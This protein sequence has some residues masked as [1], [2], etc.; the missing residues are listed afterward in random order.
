MSSTSANASAYFN[1][2]FFE[3]LREL[4]SNNRREWFEANKRRYEADVKEPMLR[5]I[6]DFGT[7][8]RTISEHLNADPRPSGGSMFRIYR[9]TRFSKDKRPYKT[10]IAA[11]FSHR[12][13]GKDIHDVPGFYLSLGPE[14]SMSGGGLWRPGATALKAVRDGIVE[15]PNEWQEVL[16][17][18]IPIGGDALKRPP[19]GYDREHPFVTDLQRKDFVTMT[20]LTEAEVCAADFMDRFV[21][22]CRTAAPLLRFLT[23]SLGLAW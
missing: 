19:A 9:D 10:N 11:R 18:G 23:K 16:S 8:L 7:R 5:F 4:E 2:G 1:P 17:T 13:G 6:A 20:E 15:R 22:S 14:R 21:D 12:T 3:F